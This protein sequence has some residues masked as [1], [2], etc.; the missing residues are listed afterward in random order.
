VAQKIVLVYQ[1]GIANVFE[2][3][4]FSRSPERRNA[5]RLLQRDF[6]SCIWFAR[7]LGAAGCVVR[8]ASCDV[9]GDCAEQ[10]WTAGKDGVFARERHAVRCN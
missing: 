1:C 7:G 2:V 5:R 4:R 10:P 9:A 3:D 8:T 6:D